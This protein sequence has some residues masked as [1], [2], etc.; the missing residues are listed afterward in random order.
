[1]CEAYAHDTTC[2][3]IQADVGLPKHYVRRSN[4][5]TCRQSS[6]PHNFNVASAGVLTK[7]ICI[8]ASAARA[9]MAIPK[10]NILMT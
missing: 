2:S 1:M 9:F 5:G 8:V 7:R 3:H 4:N 6:K 10:N